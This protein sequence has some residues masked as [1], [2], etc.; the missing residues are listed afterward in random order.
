MIDAQK[1]LDQFLGT[2]RGAPRAGAGQGG[3]QTGQ[4]GL[5]AGLPGGLGDLVG[6]VLG[7][8]SGGGRGGGIGGGM[9]G[10]LG[11]VIAGGLASYLLRGKNAKKLGGSALR[12]GGLALVAGLGYKAWQNYQAQQA[13]NTANRI[14][15][16]EIPDASDTAFI[17]PPGEEQ[18]HAR[19]LLSAMIAAA[20]ADGSIDSGEEEAIFGKMDGLE[21]DAEE[22]SLVMD[23]LR[24]PMPVEDL[25]AQARTPEAGVEVYLA[26]L[27]AIDAD[28]PAERDYLQRL[29]SALRLPPDLVAEIHDAHENA[30]QA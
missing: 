22:K 4:G 13:G 5:G 25:A 18:E 11:P 28:T 20:K 14:A 15:P 8:R 24:R 27:M 3:M 6:S 12:L 30:L 7:G 29:A 17:P 19:L 23:E 26:S 10:A 2:G 16:G 9:G 1:L 21:L